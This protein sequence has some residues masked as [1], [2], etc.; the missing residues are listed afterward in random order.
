[1]GQWRMSNEITLSDYRRIVFIMGA[2][3]RFISESEKDKLIDVQINTERLV[4][5]PW[6]TNQNDYWN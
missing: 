5:N 3:N 1:M 4:P 2:F 6:E